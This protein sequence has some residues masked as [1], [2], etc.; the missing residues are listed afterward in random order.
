MA[1]SKHKLRKS[2]GTI[3]LQKGTILYHTNNQPL[4]KISPEFSL[5]FT[6][7][8]PSDWE[9]GDYIYTI[10]LQKDITLLFM[11]ENIKNDILH[12]VLH[13]FLGNSSSNSNMKKTNKNNIKCWIPYLK[14]ENLDGWFT[15]IENKL[16][17][18]FA[19]LSDLSILKII[20]YSV[21]NSY[22]WKNV[23]NDKI[24]SKNWGTKYPISSLTKPVTMNLNSR[25]KTQIK[26]YKKY[27]KKQHLGGTVF[28]IML[29]NAKIKY[30][31]APTEEIL[32][33]SPE[34]LFKK[35]NIIKNN[36]LATK[37]PIK[38]IQIKYK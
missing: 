15:S 4:L 9:F 24:I 1:E 33:C 23:N 11:I 18:E 2:Y 8:H 13:K 34:N 17:V 36:E 16:A 21:L 28:S 22:N 5:L 38:K 6:T 35:E 37:A 26:E 25:F 31:E 27:I 3:K 19:I 29:T 30:F 7:L 32:W 12:S 20:N 10:E 14:Q